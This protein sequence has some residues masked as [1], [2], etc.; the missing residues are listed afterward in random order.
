MGSAGRRPPCHGVAEGGLPSTPPLRRRRPRA[1]APRAGVRG[2]TA[3]RASEVV[4]LVSYAAIPPRAAVVT[5]GEP[6]SMG[7]RILR[8]EL[9]YLDGLQRKYVLYLPATNL[10]T[11]RKGL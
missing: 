6:P 5:A 2:G 3:K 11:S 10:Q 7:V 4:V 1:R 8:V 9:Q